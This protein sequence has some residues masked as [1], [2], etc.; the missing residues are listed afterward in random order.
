MRERDIGKV[1]GLRRAMS[2][3]ERRSRTLLKCCLL[4]HCLRD[5]ATLIALMRDTLR[6]P[7][8]RRHDRQTIIMEQCMKDKPDETAEGVT[9]WEREL[10]GKYTNSEER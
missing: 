4:M 6:R 7:N 1:Y 10:Q 8:D 3:E 9:E 5:K 2:F